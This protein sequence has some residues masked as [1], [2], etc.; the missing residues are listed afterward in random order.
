MSNIKDETTKEESDFES[1]TSQALRMRQKGSFETLLAQ[2]LAVAIPSDPLTKIRLI[3][4]ACYMIPKGKLDIDMALVETV[5]LSCISFLNTRVNR[6]SVKISWGFQQT[7]KNYQR[8]VE[9]WHRAFPMFFVC[10]TADESEKKRNVLNQATTKAERF[11][12]FTCNLDLSVGSYQILKVQFI[13]WAIPKVM[14]FFEQLS[15]LVDPDTYKEML[16]VLKP[17]QG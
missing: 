12:L 5:Y 16:A 9:P 7:A 2:H 14:E 1:F 10:D 11:F 6:E 13:T 4:E 17:N 3:S 15:K 8:F